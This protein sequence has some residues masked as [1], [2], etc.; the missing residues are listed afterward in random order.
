MERGKNIKEFIVKYRDY[1]YLAI[2]LVGLVFFIKVITKPNDDNSKLI[3]IN[4]LKLA[5]K[6]LERD[7][8][9]IDDSLR[10]ERLKIDSISKIEDRVE[11]KRNK[12]IKEGNEETKIIYALDDSASHELFERYLAREDSIYNGFLEGYIIS[13]REAN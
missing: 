3:E 10:I 7:I 5:N 8:R 13:P 6:V 9:L 12:V 1:V 4:N 11:K 2:G